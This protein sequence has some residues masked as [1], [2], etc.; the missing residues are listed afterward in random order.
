M[1]ARPAAVRF[2]FT[3]VVLDVIAMGIIIP[4]LPGLI[5]HFVQGDTVRAA[6][7]YGIF[8]TVWALMQFFCSPIIGML[9]DRFGRR[10]VILFANFGLGLDYLVMAFA[11]TLAWLFAGRVISGITGASWT[12]AGA[13]IAD[14]TKPE[15]RAKSYGL[16]GSAWGIGFVLGPA[17]GGVLGSIDIRLPFIF[18]A[19]LTLINAMYGVFV[20]PESLPPE[21]RSAFKWAKANPLGSLA[22]LRRHR[23]LFGL[24]LVTAIYFLAHQAF[25]SVFVLYAG[26]RYAWDARAVG[27]LLAL[28]GICTA[29]VQALLVQRAVRRLGERKAIAIGLLSGSVS[30][31]IWAVAPIGWIGAL[32]VPFG[33][34]MG[35]F[36]PS[37]QALMSKHVSEQE[38]GQLQG[39][40][41]S[42]MGVVGL[43]GPTIFT[44]VFAKF[45]D[46]KG[47]MVPGAPFYLATGLSLIA[48]IL[49]WQV[50]RKEE[51]LTA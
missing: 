37:A 14:V 28:V 43:F 30:F 13:Y 10:P 25:P 22:L 49:A 35:L 5:Q 12:T 45:I 8:G 24:A 26:Y 39:A 41:A 29:L 31:L 51:A 3:T 11:P 16:I 4:V 9:S 2:I 18:A 38:Q 7:W 46:A 1:T 17:L 33:S 34:I 15:D 23:E 20:L 48:V 36:G 40:Y 50:T 6:Y 32:A 21:K 27:I 44:G 42:I 19:A 47:A